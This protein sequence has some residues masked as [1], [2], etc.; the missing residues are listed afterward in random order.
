M[1]KLS[2]A[3]VAILSFVLCYAEPTNTIHNP[4]TVVAIQPDA[5]AES[6]TPRLPKNLTER[7]VEVL[8]L[9]YTTAKQDGH[10]PE[11]LQGIVMQ[12]SSAGEASAYKVVVDGRSRFYGLTQ[13]TLAAARDVIRK[14]PQLKKQFKFQTSTDEELVAKL[15][16]NDAFNLAVASKYLLILKRFGFD[17]IKQ[18]ALAYNQG[19]GAA[20]DMDADTLD[21]VRGVM[22]NIYKLRT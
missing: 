3:M 16:E 12:E 22:S 17:T 13:I 8:T 1:K 4:T 2:L 18:L 21:Y 9:A 10:K 14:F 19:P 7:Q 6:F 5:S 15:I 11:L 20:K